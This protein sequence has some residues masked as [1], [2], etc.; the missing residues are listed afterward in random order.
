MKGNKSV[1]WKEILKTKLKFKEL[2]NFEKKKKTNISSPKI[3]L[4]YGGN[5]KIKLCYY[6]LF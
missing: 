4:F 2:P 3:K 6:P 5:R 1:V